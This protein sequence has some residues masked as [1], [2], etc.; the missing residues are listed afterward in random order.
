MLGSQLVR[1]ATSATAIW[2]TL[3]RAGRLRELLRF[4]G[5]RTA[6]VAAGPQDLF[7]ISF[8]RLQGQSTST[9]MGG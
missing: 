6:A 5:L 9:S 8:L 1:T 7:L 3:W 4:C 2:S